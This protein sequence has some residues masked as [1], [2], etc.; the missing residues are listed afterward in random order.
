[1]FDE[2]IQRLHRDGMVT[3]AVRAKPGAHRTEVVDR[4]EDGSFK[5]SVAAPPEEGKA[6]AELLRYLARMF[7]VANAKVRLVSGG[8]A[9]MKLVRIQQ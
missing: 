6:N 5:V 1:M 4:L 9:R 7:G 8:T 2:A 3:I